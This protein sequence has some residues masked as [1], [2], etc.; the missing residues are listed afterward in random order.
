MPLY[1]VDK[2]CHAFG[3]MGA[4]SDDPKVNRIKTLR[5]NQCVEDEQ[6][7]Y[8]A[9]KSHWDL[10][11]HEHRAYCLRAANNAPYKNYTMLASCVALYYEK[12]DGYQEPRRFHP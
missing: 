7:A 4:P 1:E 8:E 5:Q 2:R 9:A 3:Y 11:T 10:I 6:A 12:M